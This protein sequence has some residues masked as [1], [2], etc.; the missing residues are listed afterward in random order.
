VILVKKGNPQ[1]IQTLWDLGRQGVRLVTPNPD[2]EPGAWQNYF[3]TIYNIAAHD[4]HPPK[5]M[6]A[7]KLVNILFNGGSGDPYK[8]LAGTRIHHRDSPWSVAYGKADAAVIFYH[9]GLVTKQ[10]FPEQFDLVPLGGT[11]ADPQPLKGTVSHVRFIGRVKGDW[12]ARQIQARETLIETLLS[13]E[14]TRILKKRGL[15]QP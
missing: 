8:W 14:F 11:L 4:D 6:N 7:G 3:D 12:T 1:H 13:E 5:G 10:T 2:L 9:L 15:S